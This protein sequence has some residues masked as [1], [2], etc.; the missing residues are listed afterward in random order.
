M[1]VREIM[2]HESEIET[3]ATGCTFSVQRLPL[4]LAP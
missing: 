3:G 4:P 1:I 2:F